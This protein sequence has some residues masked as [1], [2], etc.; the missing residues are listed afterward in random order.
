MRIGRGLWLPLVAALLGA[1][2]GVTTAVVG[3][4]EP[5]RERA[6]ETTEDPLG[7]EIPFVNQDCTGKTVFV[8]G[9]G[10][11][12]A[13]V[14]YTVLNHP[15]EDLRYLST[16]S[17]CDTFWAG[18]GADDPAY[19][20]YS[21]PYD[22]PTEPCVRRMSQKRDDVAALDEGADAYVSCVCHIPNADLP[23]LRPSDETNPE[24]A[25]WVRALQHAFVD[26]DAAA[27]REAGLRRGDVNGV[28]DER[29]E[30]RVREFQEESA[31]IKPSTG[32]VETK[33]W[34]AITDRLCQQA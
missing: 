17:S 6:P 5:P 15:D 11:T 7:V 19:V 26:L 16:A 4:E 28:F 22:D 27:G 34:N 20:V 8:L 25:I 30:S 18:P 21:G 31:D 23:E 29:T 9:Y 12:A 32:V 10:D 3:D 33:T 13:A 24:L 1:T 2:A 14:R